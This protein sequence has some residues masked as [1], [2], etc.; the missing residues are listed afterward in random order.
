MV[1]VVNMWEKIGSILMVHGSVDR[2][3]LSWSADNNYPS[4]ELPPKYIACFNV[5][6]RYHLH[7][8]S[9]LNVHFSRL[10]IHAIVVLQILCR[11]CHK[12]IY[13]WI[14]LWPLHYA[15]LYIS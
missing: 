6:L 13:F 10:F 12:Y 9:S 8:S 2:H 4:R 5:C 15:Q 11:V 14:K 1:P 3:G 7:L